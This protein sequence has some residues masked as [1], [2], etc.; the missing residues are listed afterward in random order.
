MYVEGRGDLGRE[1]VFSQTDL[2]V[3]HTVKLGETK[4]LRFEFN[5]INLFNQKTGVYTYEF[6]NRRDH[7]TTTGMQMD[8]VDLR[9]G[10]DWKGLVAAGGNDL[11]PRYN[12]QSEFN[13]GF[14][15]RFLVKFIF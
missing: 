3:A 1:P 12:Q 2:T 11:D 14:A 7:R 6:Y 10:F 15:G 5:M 9:N 8:G 4:S 13:P